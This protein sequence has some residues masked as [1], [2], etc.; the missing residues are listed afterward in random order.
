MQVL[1]GRQAMNRKAVAGVMAIA[2]ICAGVATA[3]HSQAMFA[4]APVWIQGTVVRYR[5]A[6][7]HVMIELEERG[8]QGKMRRWIVEGPRMG[9]LDRILALNGGVQP[10]A[11]LKAGDLIRVCGFP[12][13]SG[14]APEGM[15]ADWRPAEDRFVHGQLLVMPDGRMQSWGPYGKLDNC[16]RE[17]D[18]VQAW[19]VLLDA[20]PLAHRQWCDSQA[21]DSQPDLVPPRLVAEVNRSMA[22]PC[23]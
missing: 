22:N 3:H 17:G 19:V 20:N 5:P 10:R 9:R 15:D 18:T 14:F 21:Y 6:D 13:R 11:F 4:A 1:D 8:P 12:L 7:P 16:I 2:L 23:R